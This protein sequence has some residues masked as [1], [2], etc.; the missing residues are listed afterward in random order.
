MVIR[1]GKNL[2]LHLPLH[3]LLM[4][5]LLLTLLMLLLLLLGWIRMEHFAGVGSVPHARRRFDLGALRLHR[6]SIRPRAPQWR[7]ISRRW[8]GRWWSW[9]WLIRDIVG[10]PIR[11]VGKWMLSR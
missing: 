7:E 4:V 2:R 9:G 1:V 11:A 10:R 3:L 8:W 6:D 5:L